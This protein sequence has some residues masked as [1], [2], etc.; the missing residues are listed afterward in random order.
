M[1]E[2]IEGLPR[3]VVGITVSGRLTMRDCQNVLVPAMENSL[4]RHDKIRLYYEL[5]S[6]FPGAAWDDL[7]LGLEYLLRCERVAIVT[8]IGWVRL[9]VKTLRFLIPSEIRVF[10][11]IEAEEGR[12]WIGARP[13][14]RRS[15]Q[16]VGPSLRAL[17]AASSQRVRHM[18]PAPR[19]RR[20]K[21]APPPPA[22]YAA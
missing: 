3:N 22:D 4:K 1:I 19:P 17:R 9:T 11:S 21:N 7:E 6:R 13:G 10:A 14:T 16:T 20:I 2:I 8:D 18:R 12:A 5:N 15:A